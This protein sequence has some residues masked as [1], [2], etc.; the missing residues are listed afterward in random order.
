[1]ILV[2]ASIQIVVAFCAE[3]R[4]SLNSWRELF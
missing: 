1:L 2:D 3:K 4:G